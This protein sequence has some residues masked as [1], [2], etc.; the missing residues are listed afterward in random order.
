[1]EENK[2]K[3]DDFTSIFKNASGTVSYIKDVCKKGLEIRDQDK[4]IEHRITY[5]ELLSK[6]DSI[7]NDIGELRVIYFDLRISHSELKH[8]YAEKERM[9]GDLSKSRDS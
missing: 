4:D 9:I 2:S 7:Q 3:L 5:L 6:L 1:V 8:A